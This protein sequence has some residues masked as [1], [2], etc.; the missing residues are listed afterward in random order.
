MRDRGLLE[1]AGCAESVHNGGGVLGLGIDGVVETTH[2]GS[3]KFASQ[4]G[5]GGAKLWESSERGLADDGDGVIGR[6]VVAVVFQGEET[7]GVD[8]AIGGIAGDDINLM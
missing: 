3:G 4:V 5:E 6:E 1:P 8:E 7:E 2:V